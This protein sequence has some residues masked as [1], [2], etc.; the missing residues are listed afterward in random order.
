MMRMPAAVPS[1]TA[2]ATAANKDTDA[3]TNS[4]QLNDDT[5][6]ASLSLEDIRKL[7]DIT[8]I[9]AQLCILNHHES[10]VD[11]Q[12][13]TFLHN[14]KHLDDT[15]DTL[16]SLRPQVA[17]VRGDV[18]Q[19]LDIVATASVLAERIS[20]SVRKLDLEQSR[21]KETLQLVQD[22]HVLK[23]CAVGVQQSLESHDYDTAAS[24]MHKYLQFN[25]DLIK[26]ITENIFP[27]DDSPLSILK[28]AQT[29]LLD[30]IST[31]FDT[32]V[33]SNNEQGISRFFKL[34]PLVGGSAIGL[35]KYS[36]YLCGIISRRCQDAM[37]N[38]ASQAPN[39]YSDMLKLLFETIAALV[40]QQEGHVEDLYGSG[41]MLRVLQRLQ[42]EADLQ[43]SIILDS[44]CENRQLFRKLAEL[45]QAYD[46]I[47]SW[48]STA[49]APIKEISMENRELD[50]IL[51]E[52]ASMSQRSQLFHQFLHT[53]A[54]EYMSCLNDSLKPA[55]SPDGLVHISKLDLRVQELMS[56]YILFEEF[57]IVRSIEKALKIDQY[58]APNQ[59]TT[60]VDDV[61]FVLKSSTMRCLS[62]LDVDILCAL[63]NSLGRILEVHYISTFQKKLA[64]VFSTTESKDSRFSF[65]VLL[66]NIDVSQEYLV[67]LARDIE[68]AADRIASKPDSTR[69]KVHS[70]LASL[71]EYAGRFNQVLKT[72]LESLFTQTIKP[73]IRPLLQDAYKDVRYVLSEEEFFE[74]ESDNVFVSR[75]VRSFDA[76]IDLYQKS[77]TDNNYNQTMAYIVDF[78][79]KDWERYLMSSHR[80]N[81]FG[82][83]RLDKD[84]RAITAYISSK[85]IWTSREKFSRLNQMCMLLNLESVSEVVSMWGNKAGPIAWRLTANEVKK[86][87]ALRT[88]FVSAEIHELQL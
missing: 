38:A 9:R 49:A 17:L 69:G 66:N 20:G 42:R 6:A 70:C 68:D 54:K 41:K 14:Q 5:N 3:S 7:T 53:R 65:M 32:A 44:F 11:A 88:D 22:I 51:T 83:V 79:V 26:S 67:R 77:Y 50:M 87:L 1:A 60:C 23:V 27:Q 81:Q 76:L 37:A 52:L 16:E 74:S 59:T 36:A 15:L 21:V 28:T 24:H 19:L 62:S 78:L 63:I 75:F 31:Q 55:Q 72:W 29:T 47:A 4:D 73:R 33:H 8:H 34:F 48:K 13:D 30:I 45:K 35:D 46:S 57:F 39:V 18:G 2:T 56:G 86:C 80:F 71:N 10:L 43:S 84:I 85:T 40:D 61:F 82:A 25:P 58:E 64:S 12:L